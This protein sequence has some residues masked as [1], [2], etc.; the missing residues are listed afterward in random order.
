MME[1]EVD[2]EIALM[3]AIFA[4]PLFMAMFAVLLLMFRPSADDLYDDPDFWGAQD[5]D[6]R[7]KLNIRNDMSDNT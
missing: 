7:K 2:K 4:V 1:I 6:K 5:M 3:L